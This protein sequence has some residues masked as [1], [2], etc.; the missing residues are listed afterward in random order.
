MRL[1]LGADTTYPVSLYLHK[2]AIK[3][4]P[5]NDP[6]IPLSVAGVIKELLKASMTVSRPESNVGLEIPKAGA[7]SAFIILKSVVLNTRFKYS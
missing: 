3:L 4:H 6:I 7:T 2:Y 1:L 5:I